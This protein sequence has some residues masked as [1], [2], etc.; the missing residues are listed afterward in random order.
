MVA[1]RGLG[2][3]YRRKPPLFTGLDLDLSDG[4][5]YGLLGK[6]G[7]G[8][9]TLLKLI[10]GLL[11]PRAGACT[12]LDENPRRRSPE[13]LKQIYYVPEELYL[14]RLDA[15]SYADLYGRFYPLFDPDELK[16]CLRELE[17]D[18]RERL[19]TLSYGQKRKFLLAFALASGCRLVILDEPTNG[20][21]IP[22]K[23]QLRRLIASASRDKRT[24]LIST[25]QVRD[26]E[27]LLES[28]IIVDG[29]RVILSRDLRGAAGRFAMRLSAQEPDPARALYVEKVVGGY[30]VITERRDA[31]EPAIDLETLFNMTI[32]RGGRGEELLG[33]PAGEE[34]R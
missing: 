1:I 31:D 28:I 2:F 24:F 9:T 14:P 16:R 3:A 27:G 17:V 26:M 32:A 12:V 30:A 10:C 34:K 13:L 22:S 29:G 8:K 23:S 11:F 21:D 15:A 18:D 19:A 25:H 4:V 33:S 5:I 6:N 7:A 20:L